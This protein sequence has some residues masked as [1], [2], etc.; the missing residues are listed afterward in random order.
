MQPFAGRKRR[1]G[2]RNDGYLVRNMDPMSK[3][4]PYIMT[5]MTDSWVLFE[6]KID[7]THTQEFIRDMRAGRIPGLTLYQVIFA[8]MVRTVSQV[9]QINRFEQNRRVY[10]R[11]HIKM[12][13]VVKKGMSLAGERTTLMP[14]F[15][16]ADTL[17]QVVE[18]INGEMNKIDRTVTSVEEDENKTNF[19]ALEV[20]L[21]SIPNFLM[22]FVFWLL[23]RL[24]KWG[25]LPRAL[26]DL[27]PFHTTAFITNMGSF[28]MDAVYHHIYEFGTLSI[29]GAIGN[30]EVVYETQRDGSVKRRVYLHMKFVADERI[31][32][33]F[34]YGLAFKHIKSYIGKPE[35]LLD[36]PET[37]VEDVI[38][39][40]KRKKK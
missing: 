13:M 30:K 37:V 25:L 33:G 3:V 34:S 40:P 11:N 24:D 10:A 18:K 21:S 19:D 12:A 1:W 39:K 22:K 32:D 26:T 28:G 29:F 38:D 6:D 35:K 7:I 9:P 27:S 14:F 23:K 15:D 20:A 5:T 4:V 31:T 36:P 16:P 2:D 17:D 8:A